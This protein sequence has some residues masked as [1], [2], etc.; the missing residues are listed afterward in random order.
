MLRSLRR[1][2]TCVL[3][4]SA[5]VSDLTAADNS[6]GGV[7][8]KLGGATI[9]GRSL[10]WTKSSAAVLGTDGRLWQFASEQAKDVE[11]FST[12]APRSTSR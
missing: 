1:I 8:L 9:E 4:L 2:L 10:F 12:A 3:F 11:R 7:R 5:L 6:S